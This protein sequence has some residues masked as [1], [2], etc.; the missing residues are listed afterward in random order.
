MQRT[1]ALWRIDQMRFIVGPKSNHLTAIGDSMRRFAADESRGVEAATAASAHAGHK[2]AQQKWSS[3]HR[4]QPHRRNL[5][6]ITSLSA[7]LEDQLNFEFARN[8]NSMNVFMIRLRR[9]YQ[10]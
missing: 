8:K 4:G 1:A 6:K 10:A 2:E 3:I 9:V 7:D 5:Q